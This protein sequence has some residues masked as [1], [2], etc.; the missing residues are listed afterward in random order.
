MYA[1]N[2]RD[3]GALIWARYV[4]QSWYELVGVRRGCTGRMARTATVMILSMAS[5]V[6][7]LPKLMRTRGEYT[8]GGTHSTQR[9]TLCRLMA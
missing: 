5:E 9:D 2:V 3:R 4:P 7:L 1:L 6:P 8:L